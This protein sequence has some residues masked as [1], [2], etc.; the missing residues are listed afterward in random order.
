MVIYIKLL[1]S[2]RDIL[3]RAN[4]DIGLIDPYIALAGHDF[5]L[6]EYAR[7]CIHGCVRSQF[8]SLPQGM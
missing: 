2:G 4:G 3:R 1:T 8:L 7:V 5:L 6:P